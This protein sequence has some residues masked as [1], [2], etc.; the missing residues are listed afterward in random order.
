MA[1]LQG[2]FLKCLGPNLKTKK[3]KKT[4]TT[5]MFFLL[6]TGGDYWSVSCSDV[7]VIFSYLN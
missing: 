3:K 2:S 6:P 1:T 4:N 5:D 7:Q